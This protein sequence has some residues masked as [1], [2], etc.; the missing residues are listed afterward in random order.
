MPTRTIQTVNPATGEKLS[1]YELFSQ[2]KALVLA[3]RARSTFETK[4]SRVSVA[5]RADYL[6][7]LASSL[8]S[9][10]SEYARLMTLEMGKPIS[11]AEAEVEK[12]AW[13]AEYYAQNA[14]Q[15]LQ[16]EFVT[17]DAKASY[18]SFEPLGVILSIMPWNFPFW[19]AFRF[20]IPAIVAGN[21]TILRHASACPGSALAI[22]EAFKNAGFPEGVLTTV[23]TDHDLVGKLIESDCISGVSLTGSTEAGQRVGELAA[24][25]FKKFVLE[26]GGSDPFIVLEDANVDLAAQVGAA[27]RLQNSGQSCIC[28]KRFIVVRSVSNEFTEKF[29]REFEKKNVGDPLDKKTDVGPLVNVEAVK[30]ID[31]QVKDAVSKG[32][33][34][35]FGGSAITPGFYYRPTVLDKVDKRMKV[36]Y[37]E[38]FGPVAPVC[39]VENEAQAIR[40][41][42]DSEFGLGASLWT[43]S[44]DKAKRLAKEI[45][46][47]MVFVNEF[48]KSDPRMPFGGIKKSG[49]GRELS[50]YGLKEFVNVKS[51]NIYAI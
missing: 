31:S 22:E 18:V 16:D 30:T 6:R 41:A 26:L 14:E 11:Q 48:T 21:T 46:S 44:A 2:E 5:E 37:E 47:G 45:Q 12:C 39:V 8:R 49:M 19:Q 35:E 1:T 17:T 10:K 34:T 33:A 42:N 40:T 4:W 28:A 25:N 38:V 36:M 51:T 24:R 29:V 3:K 13:G 7:K 43:T 9:K 23:I 50:K 15:W 20:A 27:A 32:A